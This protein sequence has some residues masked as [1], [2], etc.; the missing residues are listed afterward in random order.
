MSLGTYCDNNHPKPG[1]NSFAIR[2]LSYRVKDDYRYPPRSLKINH[3]NHPAGREVTIDSQSA[4]CEYAAGVIAAL[5]PRF[6]SEYGPAALVP[7]PSS[8]VTRATMASARWGSL[9]LCRALERVGFGA[10]T[11]CVVFK[12]KKASG[13][14]T[15]NKPKASEL[16][17]LL[18]VIPTAAPAPGQAVL[19]VDDIL[20]KGAHV[21]AIDDILSPHAPG[22]LRCAFAIGYT[23][24][25]EPAEKRAVDCYKIRKPYIHYDPLVTS[26]WSTAEE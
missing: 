12:Q 13:Y 23:E 22:R 20:S 24:P 18:E 26:W 8:D 1:S 16:R 14:K 4:A 6:P 17:K 10:T 5:F 9:A 3:P 7:V 25:H 2:E 15:G 21:A 19:Y 11:P